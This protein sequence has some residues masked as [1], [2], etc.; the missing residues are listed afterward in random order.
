MAPPTFEEPLPV[1]E[2]ANI[3]RLPFARNKLLIVTQSDQPSLATDG[4]HLPDVIHIHQCI[5]MNSS[6]AGVPEALIKCLKGLSGEVF[7]LCGDNPDDIA[8][9]LKSVNFVR[10]E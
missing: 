4:T 6:K 9:R 7:L 3:S 2:L 10:A 8:I 5:T 1:Q